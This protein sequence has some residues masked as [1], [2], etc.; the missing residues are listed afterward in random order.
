MSVPP[1]LVAVSR[2][3]FYA[4]ITALVTLGLAFLVFSTPERRSAADAAYAEIHAH[5]IASRCLFAQ[6]AESQRLLA[7]YVGAPVEDIPPVDTT[8]L[9]CNGPGDLPPLAPSPEAP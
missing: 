4:V 2:M 9:D 6:L 7:E 3:L 5:R 8:G 1:W